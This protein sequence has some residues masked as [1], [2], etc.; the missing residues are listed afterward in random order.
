MHIQ[1]PDCKI[2]AV[3]KERCHCREIMRSFLIIGT[4]DS[5]DIELPTS[6]TI[7]HGKWELAIAS[8]VYMGRFQ[9]S[10]PL[11]VQSNICH[12]DYI[13]T[14]NLTVDCKTI[15]QQHLSHTWQD[16]TRV[17][18]E[19]AWHPVNRATQSVQ[20]VIKD[21]RNSATSPSSVTPNVSCNLHFFL[22]RVA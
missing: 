18:F 6:V 13:N 1:T 9:L 14:N 7:G 16:Q 5:L 15:L 3:A 20:F 2:Q 10:R 17:Q 11:V 19:L 22:R 8:I 4:T 21:A 12:S